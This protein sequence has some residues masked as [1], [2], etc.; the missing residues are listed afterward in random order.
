[1]FT[2]PGT[3]NGGRFPVVAPGLKGQFINEIVLGIN[4]D[5]GWDVAVGA[6][7]IHRD[8]GN[9]IEDLSPNGGSFYIIANPGVAADPALVEQLKADVERLKAAGTSP[10]ATDKQ[11]LD[12]KTPKLG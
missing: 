10:T 8:L 4:Y 1:M 7:Y 3:I 9:I 6:S 12:Y 11:K 5:I 2:D